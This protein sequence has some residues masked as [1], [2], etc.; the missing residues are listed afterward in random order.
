[1]ASVQDVY[2]CA[3]R[4][5]DDTLIRKAKG[6]ATDEGTTLPPPSSRQ[7]SDSTSSPPAH[8]RQTLPAQAPHEEGASGPQHRPRNWDAL[9]ERIE[10]HG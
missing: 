9:Y 7:R 5:L 8:W 4:D 10:S 2:A 6:R 3:R 1:M